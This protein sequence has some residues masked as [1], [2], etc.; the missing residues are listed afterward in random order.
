MRWLRSDVGHR[1][2]SQLLQDVE[3]TELKR[4]KGR[5]LGVGVW[6][7]LLWWVSV[8]WFLVFAWETLKSCGN[9]LR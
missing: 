7:R 6:G 3:E 9:L 5:G 1:E 4:L 2:H 8:P